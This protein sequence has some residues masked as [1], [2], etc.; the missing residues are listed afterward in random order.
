MELIEFDITE[1]LS[2]DENR[3]NRFDEELKAFLYC[4]EQKH[5]QHTSVLPKIA[6]PPTSTSISTFEPPESTDD[7]QTSVP[8]DVMSHMNQNVEESE[9]S[10]S[11]QSRP[12]T[13]YHTHF[14]KHQK[15]V[16]SLHRKILQREK[17]MDPVNRYRKFKQIYQRQRQRQFIR[18]RST[19]NPDSNSTFRNDQSVEVTTTDSH[20][21]KSQRERDIKYEWDFDSNEGFTKSSET[22]VPRDKILK[23]QITRVGLSLPRLVESDHQNLCTKSASIESQ[24]PKMLKN[25]KNLDTTITHVIKFGVPPFFE[26]SRNSSSLD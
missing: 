3:F 9:E 14:R 25:L 20:R 18:S 7:T 13:P 8:S 2:F 23:K 5:T 16:Q 19:L 1:I 24:N 12:E 10:E 26:A 11:E 21:E 6:E 22:V 17:M 4:D 15:R